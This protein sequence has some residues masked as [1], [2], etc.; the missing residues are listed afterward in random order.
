MI[1]MWP[2]GQ[3]GQSCIAGLRLLAARGEKNRST[4]RDFIFCACSAAAPHVHED[5]AGAPKS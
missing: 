4:E 5:L 2:Y 3:S 1:A